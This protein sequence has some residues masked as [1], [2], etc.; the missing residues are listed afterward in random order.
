MIEEYG[1]D[2][3]RISLCAC[4][5]Q[6]PQIDL[7]RRRFEEFKNFANKVWNG[8]RFVFMHLEDLSSEELAKGLDEK[9]LTLEDRWILSRL[10]RVNEQI[11][12]YLSSYAFE[13][14]ATLAYEFFWKEFCAYYVEITKAIL[15]NKELG[16]ERRNKQKL[17]VIVLCDAIRLMHP[18]TPFITEEL[19]Q[20]LKGFFPELA[21]KG[22]CDPYTEELLEALA[23]PACI[24]A[25]YPKVV[26]TGVVC[27][28]LKISLHS[29][30]RLSIRCVI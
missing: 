3:V 8:A 10:N 6:T 12:N 29:L 27:Q 26:H 24:S 20:A 21:A 9:L 13:N 19:F 16:A 1:T 14:A 28:R 5:N 15:Y 18:M 23:S 7:D 22:K 17:L 30:R 11:S 25:P 4:A 2:A